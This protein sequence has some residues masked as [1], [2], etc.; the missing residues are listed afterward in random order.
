MDSSNI[1]KNQIHLTGECSRY[2][3]DPASET[4]GYVKMEF[5]EDK[6]LI[7]AMVT[8]IKFFPDNTYTYNVILAG[9][10]SEKWHYHMLGTLTSNADGKGEG[11]FRI[12]TADVNGNGF[13]LWDYNSI[14]IAARSTRNCRESLHPVLKGTFSL[15]SNSICKKN[16]SPKD[17]SPFYNKYILERCIEIAKIQTQ[18]I[19]VI[20]FK[21]D[22]TLAKWK[23]ITDCK[24]FPIIAPG[25]K[26]PMNIYGHFIF[27][28]RDS[29]YF[30][31]IPGRFFPEEQPDEGKSGFVFWQPLLGMEEESQDKS[32][33]VE[34]RRE[35]IYGYW[36]ASINRYNGHIEEIPLIDD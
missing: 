30:L 14:I 3:M 35:N 31:G 26:H 13:A 10:K 12:T 7:T 20:P 2:A 18:F 15:D 32:I 16:A 4:Q 6:C 22:L 25:A 1:N 29:H 24:L 36:I 17:Y 5:N 27:G 9:L 23:K 34:K 33:P 11:T 21:H 19:D 28:W 8:N